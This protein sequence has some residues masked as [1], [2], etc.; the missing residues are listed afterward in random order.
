MTNTFTKKFDVKNKV[1]GYN[2]EGGTQEFFNWNVMA[3]AGLI[4]SNAS[5]MVRYLKAVLNK[6]TAIGKAAMITERIFYKDEKRELGLGTNIMADEKNI[7][8]QKSGDAMGQSSIIC[9]NRVKNWGI[10][11]L[12]N[13]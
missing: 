10:I 9:Y 12:I 2:P 3:S 4:K 5:D 1:V 8:Y 7:L 11:I 6:E 13:Q